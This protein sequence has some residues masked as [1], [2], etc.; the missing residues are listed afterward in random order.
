[1]SESA[2]F[3]SLVSTHSRPKAAGM[4]AV[5]AAVA[6]GVSTHSRPKAAGYCFR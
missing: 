4:A 3:G 2:D 6:G 1:M 5:L